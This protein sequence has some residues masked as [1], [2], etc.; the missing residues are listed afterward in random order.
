MERDLMR[1]SSDNLSA[2]R[3]FLYQLQ[4]DVPPRPIVYPSPSLLR[5]IRTEIAL[6]YKV[7]ASIH[8][9]RDAQM[10]KRTTDPLEL[11]YTPLPPPSVADYLR[12]KKACFYKRLELRV[13][14]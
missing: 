12:Q 7:L 4:G 2:R 1:D 5:Q 8:T 10:K 13:N 3:D 9:Q 11:L 6:L 14:L